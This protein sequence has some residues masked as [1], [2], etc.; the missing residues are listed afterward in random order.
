MR[1]EEVDTEILKKIGKNAFKFKVNWAEKI[2]R[3]YIPIFVNSLFIFCKKKGCEG[4]WGEKASND[5]IQ[6][7]GKT[8]RHEKN[9]KKRGSYSGG[10]IDMNSYSVKFD[11]SD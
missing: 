7:R 1:E 11:D 4:S 5:L 2:K 3:Q 6:T 9:K 8:F 10:K